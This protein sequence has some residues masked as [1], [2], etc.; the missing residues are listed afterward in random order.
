MRK[1]KGH[2]EHL[3]FTSTGTHI[4]DFGDSVGWITK[5]VVGRRINP[6]KTRKTLA[7]ALKG[8]KGTTEMDMVA[9]AKA[10]HHSRD[11]QE[12][13]YVDSGLE[14]IVRL[15][16]KFHDGQWWWRKRLR[17]RWRTGAECGQGWS[18]R[19]VC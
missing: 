14:D 10:G 12:N 2:E 9:F 19:E 6:H 13:Y 17:S 7:T 15:Q 18:R 8:M 4:T 5:K 16:A 1:L 11:T 3:F